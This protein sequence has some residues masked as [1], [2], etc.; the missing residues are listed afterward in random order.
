MKHKIYYLFI[1]GLFLSGCVLVEPFKK[2]LGTS[3]QSLEKAK[4]SGVS[5]IYDYKKEVCFNKTLTVL[6]NMQAYIFIED[7]QKSVIVVMN[8]R[9]SEDLK[10]Q[11]ETDTTELGIF[12]EK[13]ELNKTKI[14]I[15]SLS[16]V[17]LSEYSQKIFDNLDKELAGK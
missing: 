5:K 8:L 9:K 15:T 13:Q 14:T 16:K 4:S 10:K 1:I 11:D 17:L 7:R 12:F 6:K 2:F 3:T